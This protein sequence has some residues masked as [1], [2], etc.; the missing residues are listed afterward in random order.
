MLKVQQL[1]PQ[2]TRGTKK[3]FFFHYFLFPLRAPLD[4]QN[5]L[6]VKHAE[7]CSPKFQIFPSKNKVPR[8]SSFFHFFLSKIFSWHVDWNLGNAA[9]KFWQKS[10]MI[11]PKVQKVMK[12]HPFFNEKTSQY[13]S[14]H[15][16]DCFDNP[17]RMALLK[18]EKIPLKK[19][20]VSEKRI[21]S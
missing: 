2:D 11:L 3:P 1:F 7:I 19:Q 18:V 13:F 16:E 20:K 21:Y 15:A 10:A 6:L 12:N 14:G 8:K 5:A 4:T 9:V 17:C